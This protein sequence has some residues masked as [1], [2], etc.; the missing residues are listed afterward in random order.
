MGPWAFFAAQPSA[1]PALASQIVEA[2]AA[3]DVIDGHQIV[4]GVLIGISLALRI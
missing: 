3:P 1:V 2:I 4:I